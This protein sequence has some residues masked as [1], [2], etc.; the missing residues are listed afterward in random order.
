MSAENAPLVPRLPSLRL[1]TLHVADVCPPG[2][3]RFFQVL[4]GRSIVTGVF[5]TG[6]TPEAAMAAFLLAWVKTFEGQLGEDPEQILHERHEAHVPTPLPEKVEW[7]HV[8]LVQDA[9][10]GRPG[11]LGRRM[12]MNGGPTR[13]VV[14]RTKAQSLE[15]FESQ[16]EL[17]Q[18]PA[19]DLWLEVMAHHHGTT[20]LEVAERL[21]APKDLPE[22]LSERLR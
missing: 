19:T 21:Y 18:Q 14:I 3:D 8:S 10:F 20:R 13:G 15:D 2:E 5:G 17:T 4:A 16:T 22:W 7:P 11:R 12:W 6:P 1:P 9:P